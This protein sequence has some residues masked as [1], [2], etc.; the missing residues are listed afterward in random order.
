[1][2]PVYINGLSILGGEPFEPEN[3]EGLVEFVEKVRATYPQKS[4]WMYSGHTWDQLTE[5]KWHTESPSMRSRKVE[6]PKNCQVWLWR[7]T[8]VVQCVQ[9]TVIH[10][11]NTVA[12]VISHTSHRSC[13]ESWVT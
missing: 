3:Q 13:D 4:I 6:G 1:M 10:F 5:G 8:D 12:T 7:V 11:C 9:E 2:A